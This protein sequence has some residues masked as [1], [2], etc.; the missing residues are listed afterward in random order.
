MDPPVA[1]QNIRYNGTAA[2]VSPTIPTIVAWR[3]ATC[4]SFCEQ[5]AFPRAQREEK[6]RRRV[7]RAPEHSRRSSGSCR[8]RARARHRRGAERGLD[9][10]PPAAEPDEMAKVSDGRTLSASRRARSE[11]ARYVTAHLRGGGSE[12]AGCPG[13][14]RARHSCPAAEIWSTAGEGSWGDRGSGSPPL[15]DHLRGRRATKGGRRRKSAAGP[16]C[17]DLGCCRRSG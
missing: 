7:K 16:G 5:Y 1:W 13:K 15:R 12:A 17:V 6:R 4:V 3:G 2:Y 10:T 8:R 9:G 11:G 14:D